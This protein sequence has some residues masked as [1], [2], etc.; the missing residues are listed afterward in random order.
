MSLT[1]TPT[2]YVRLRSRIRIQR[3]RS[4]KLGDVAHLL[5]SP[6][7]Q[8][9][10]LLEL[11]LLRP[12]PEDGNLILIDILQIIPQ[13]RRVLPDVTVELIGSGHTLVEVVVGSG[14]PSKSLFILVWLLLFFGS[15]LTIMNFHADV[16]MQ[17]VQ[18]RIVEMITG[19][20]D[21]HPYLFQVAY[22]IGI[23]F[24]MAVFFNHL[25]K[26]KWNEEPTPLEVEM[27]LYQ[28]NV[29]KYVVI[30]ETERMH[31]EERREMNADERS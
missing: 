25:F 23:G 5:T 4:V 13:I 24:G 16:N 14:K 7:E 8:E 6:E 22:S 26:K 20:R 28:Q 1:P 30:E 27:F 10:R 15:A 21:E 11:E 19:R 12:G 31:E 17:E 29:D 2:V 18:I 3:G 9:R